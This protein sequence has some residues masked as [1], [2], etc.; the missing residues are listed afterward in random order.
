MILLIIEPIIS[1]NFAFFVSF[2][3][4][5]CSRSI[6]AWKIHLPRAKIDTLVTPKFKNGPS[7][8]VG[9]GRYI[10]FKGF[11]IMAWY[12]TRPLLSQDLIKNC[13]S[14]GRNMIL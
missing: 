14:E 7:L 10:Q 3:D 2:Q 9:D 1:I 8:L 11:R 12:A 4:Q 13:V 5:L 6:F